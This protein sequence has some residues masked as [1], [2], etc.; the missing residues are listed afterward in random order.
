MPRRNRRPNP[1]PQMSK[2]TREIAEYTP[3]SE[4]NRRH[5]RALHLVSVQDSL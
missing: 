2:R 5:V 4:I 1:Q 3:M